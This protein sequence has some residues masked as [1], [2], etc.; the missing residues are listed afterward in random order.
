M[1]QLSRCFLF[2]IFILASTPASPIPAKEKSWIEI[3][4]PQFTVFSDAGEKKARRIIHEFEKFHA[5]IRQFIPSIQASPSIPTI[6]LAA[7]NERSR[8]FGKKGDWR[9][10]PEYLSED[11]RETMW[12][13]AWTWTTTFDITLSTMSMFIFLCV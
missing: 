10:L 9:I 11:R 5:V 1:K 7:E 8:S 3:S 12:R 6:I 13:F 2:L 4:S